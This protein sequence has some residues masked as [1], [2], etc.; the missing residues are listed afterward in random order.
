MVRPRTLAH[1][2]AA[3]LAASLL[4]LAAPGISASAETT[5]PDLA[6]GAL[7]QLG[8]QALITAAGQQPGETVMLSPYGLGVGLS[9]LAQGATD[10]SLGQLTGLLG[11]GA[12]SAT[13]A[14]L[15]ASLAERQTVTLAEANGVW[16]AE[17]LTAQP[18]F[19]ETVQGVFGG[20]VETADFADP[21]TVD[22]LDAWASE[23][24]QGR[25]DG[26]VETLPPN[27]ILVIANAL[28]FAG[29]WDRAFDPEDTRDWPFHG[30]S[31]TTVVPMMHH[32]GLD[33]AVLE[34][35][36][37][38]AI[39]L[40]FADDLVLS[41]VQPASAQPLGAWLAAIGP[42]ALAEALSERTA[43]R[44]AYVRMPRLA[45]ASELDLLTVLESLGL[46]ALSNFSGIAEGPLE[47][48]ALLQRVAFSADE[49]G[50]EA[51]AVTTAIGTRS[52]LTG[53]IAEPFVFTVDRPTLMA[54]RDRATGAL[55]FLVLLQQ[56]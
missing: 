43:L 15:Q 45:L 46:T 6:A 10:E 18:A 44:P 17:A 32:Y 27:A 42:Q 8:L 23:A 7:N 38:R 35:D 12:D 49:E 30:A 48:S 9:V 40:P 14:A 21:A 16:L 31:H 53:P 54:V 47:I 34:T 22:R 2:R 41:L 26:L 50:A 5:E 36:A 3:L 56:L 51:A 25:I 13:L 37:A 24:T 55:L 1:L 11:P 4:G 29:H 28:Y 52:A 20:T 33:A 19:V 39:D